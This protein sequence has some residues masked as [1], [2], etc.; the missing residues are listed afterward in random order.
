MQFAFPSPEETRREKR[1]KL[2]NFVTG[3]ITGTIVCLLLASRVILTGFQNVDF[4]TWVALGFGALSFAF[5]A[6]WFGDAFWKTLLGLFR[7][8]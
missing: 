7:T 3:L 2:R 1:K 4:L 8:N 5:L 6:M